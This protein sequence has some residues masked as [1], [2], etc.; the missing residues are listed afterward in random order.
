MD[1][2]GHFVASNRFLVC[3]YSLLFACRPDKP[4]QKMVL[5]AVPQVYAGFPLCG[6][7]FCLDDRFQ[8][9]CP[10]CCLTRISV[11][12]RFARAAKCGPFGLW[13]SSRCSWAAACC[14]GATAAAA[15]T[16]W[17][18]QYTIQSRCAPPPPC[19]LVGGT[20]CYGIL[21]GIRR[22]EGGGSVGLREVR[23]GMRGGLQGRVWGREQGR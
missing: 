13:L 3:A 16:I 12:C 22:Q 4:D 21:G 19:P 11:L 5:I 14:P 6:Q 10:P 9:S 15:A 8:T 18:S 17:S 23:R 7:L 2:N 20:R 1:H